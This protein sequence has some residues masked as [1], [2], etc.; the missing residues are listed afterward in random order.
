[1][2]KMKQNYLIT[3]IAAEI[4][5]LICAIVLTA[6]SP[7]L[8]AAV[9]VFGILLVITVY[10]FTKDC[11][12]KQE[13]KQQM[14]EQLSNRN[15]QWMEAFQSD[16]K[17]TLHIQHQ[18][19]D[20][21]IRKLAEMQEQLSANNSAWM[22]AFRVSMTEVLQTQHQETGNS[23][24]KLAELQEQLLKDNLKLCSNLTGSVQ[25]FL[26]ENGESIQSYRD[27]MEKLVHSLEENIH[28]NDTLFAKAIAEMRNS[29]DTL[30]QNSADQINALR[31]QQ[32]NN[33]QQIREAIL[34]L[35]EMQSRMLEDHDTQSKNLRDNITE[36]SRLQSEEFQK[37]SAH[38]LEEMR[39]LSEKL[40]TYSFENAQKMTSSG[41]FPVHVPTASTAT[42]TAASSG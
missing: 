34:N 29:N 37:L 23:I 36:M 21:E 25:A 11:A 12:N 42:F 4:L 32:A 9:G 35:N 39:Q 28:Q 17:E 19:T 10:L 8:W 20:E 26:D 24:N 22:D 30:L 41:S 5:L 27:T 13:E 7:Y 31:N 6:L 38:T 3:A 18:K 2:S 33:G 1:M 14:E 15:F 16:L 40:K